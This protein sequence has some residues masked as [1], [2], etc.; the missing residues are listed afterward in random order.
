MERGPMALFG[1]IVALGLGPA[2]WLGAQFGEATVTPPRQPSIITQQNDVTGPEGGSGAGDSP[3]EKA[4]VVRSEPRSN[5]EP[6]TPR[7]KPAAEKTSPSTP[8][9][10]ASSEKSTPPTESTTPPVEKPEE[11]AT[12]PSGATTEPGTPPTGDNPGGP[13][14]PPVPPITEQELPSGTG[15]DKIAEVV[16]PANL[17]G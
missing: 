8:S 9:P 5:P 14:L 3:E 11:P 12:P 10:S 2:M 4:R 6:L 13:V 17:Q 16:A 15:T 7:T 1:A